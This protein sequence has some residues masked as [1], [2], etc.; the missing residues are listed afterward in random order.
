MLNI[1]IVEKSGILWL[2]NELIFRQISVSDHS[3]FD[4]N[5]IEVANVDAEASFFLSWI[6]PNV[7]AQL[8]AR[9][10]GVIAAVCLLTSVGHI[11]VGRIAYKLTLA[12]VRES[13]DAR[14]DKLTGL[15]N[16]T[17]IDEALESRHIQRALELNRLAIILI[18]MD[19]F[20]TI[21]DT[22]GHA[23]GDRALQVMSERL[24]TI[25]RPKD[26]VARM[27]GDEFM[28]VVIDDTPKVA[29]KLLVQRLAEANQVPADLGAGD[30]TLV[31][32]SLGFAAATGD[33]GMRQ[34]MIEADRSMY[35]AKTAKA[36]LQDA[37]ID[38]HS[39]PLTKT[40]ALPRKATPL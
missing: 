8:F 35:D 6:P 5:F 20:K 23:A 19:R 15:L 11:I 17:G 12:F 1:A 27:G 31:Q 28:I 3:P 10:L 9:S 34:L 26:I 13:R 18:D 30:D 38:P 39:P 22:Y 25:A 32:A 24:Q 37:G 2:P 16:R 36:F 7:G 40:Q 29:A 4:S 33:T 14:V 21:N